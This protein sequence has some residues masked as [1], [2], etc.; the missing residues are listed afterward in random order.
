MGGEEVPLVR[1]GAH[2]WGRDVCVNPLI[3]TSTPGDRCYHHPAFTTENTRIPA[4]GAWLRRAGQGPA[5]GMNLAPYVP[6]A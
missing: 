6:A 1:R 5:P 3:L 2:R 4:R